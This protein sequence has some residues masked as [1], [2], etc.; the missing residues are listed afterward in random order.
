MICRLN[1]QCSSPPRKLSL[2]NPNVYLIP[3]IKDLSNH[4]IVGPFG[5]S[6]GQTHSLEPWVG[7]S[8]LRVEDPMGWFFKLEIGDLSSRFTGAIE[9]GNP[10]RVVLQG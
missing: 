2:K 7:E 3:L 1:K 9:H 5:F 8:T 6:K 10:A 4:L